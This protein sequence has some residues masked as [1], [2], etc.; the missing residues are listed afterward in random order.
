MSVFQLGA[1]PEHLVDV[2]LDMQTFVS[3]ALSTL[4]LNDM[5]GC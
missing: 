3:D 4:S 5:S 2:M 1:I